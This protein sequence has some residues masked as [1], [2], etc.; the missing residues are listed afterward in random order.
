MPRGGQENVFRITGLH[1]NLGTLSI[2][3]FGIVD[4]GDREEQRRREFVRF[5]AV[6]LQCSR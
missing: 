3:D 1:Q 2:D 5:L 6:V 4:G